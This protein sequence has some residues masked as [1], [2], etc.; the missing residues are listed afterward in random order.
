MLSDKPIDELHILVYDVF[1]KKVFEKQT[2]QLVGRF[3]ETIDLSGMRAG[4]Y[5]IQL[6]EN[7][8]PVY[9]K[10]LIKN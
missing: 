5:L 4:M 8:K 3:E 6:K 2:Q 9:A 7:G 10:K 1:G